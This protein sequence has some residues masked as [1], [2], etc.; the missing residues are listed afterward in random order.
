LAGPFDLPANIGPVFTRQ[1]NLTRRKQPKT[2]LD[3]LVWP[4]HLRNLAPVSLDAFLAVKAK[5]G[6]IT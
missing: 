3:W 4:Y 2:R 6:G 5:K 1:K